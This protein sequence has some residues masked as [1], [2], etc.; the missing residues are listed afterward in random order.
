MR[1]VDVGV[2]HDDDAVAQLVGVV[3]VLPKPVPSAV[4]SVTISASSRAEARPPAFRIL[5]RNGMPGT[6]DRVPAWRSRPRSRPRPGRFRTARVAPWQSAACPAVQAVEHAFAARRS[7]ACARP[8]DTRGVD[9]L[10]ADDLG[11]ERILEQEF[12][13]LRRYDLPARSAALPTTRACPYLRRE[14]VPGPDGQHAADPRA[15]RRRWS[16]PW[17]SSRSLPS[18]CSG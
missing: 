14:L 2:G 9:D 5:P 15:C 18:R 17:P 13:E 12:G 16:R 4:M 7:R 11:V 6:C 10:R 1:A 3:L 8:R